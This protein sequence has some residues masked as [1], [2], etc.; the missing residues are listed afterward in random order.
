MNL[1]FLIYRSFRNVVL[2][3]VRKVRVD[4]LWRAVVDVIDEDVQ[5][6]EEGVGDAAV[7]HTVGGVLGK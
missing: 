4:E 2:Y 5:D 7:S 1:L 3:P 6:K